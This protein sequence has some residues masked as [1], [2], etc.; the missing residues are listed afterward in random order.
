M[1]GSDA[2]AP[3]R[4]PFPFNHKPNPLDRDHLVIP[5]GWDSWGKIEIVRQFEPRMWGDAWDRDLEDDGLPSEEVGAKKMFTSLVP[6]QGTKVCSS[7]PFGFEPYLR[8]L[9]RTVTS[10]QQ[11]NARTNIPCQEL[12]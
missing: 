3:I 8:R 10:V 7:C 1:A 4:N 5:A 2:P 9:A 11:P 12:R 6:D